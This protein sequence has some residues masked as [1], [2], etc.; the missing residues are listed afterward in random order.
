MRRSSEA[1]A[2]AAALASASAAAAASFLSSSSCSARALASAAAASAAAL[3]DAAACSA[4][5]GTV[6]REEQPKVVMVVEFKS[7]NFISMRMEVAPAWAATIWR[8]NPSDASHMTPPKAPHSRGGATSASLASMPLTAASRGRFTQAAQLLPYF[9]CSF[10]ACSTSPLPSGPQSPTSARKWP[11]GTTLVGTYTSHLTLLY[12]TG[13]M[14]LCSHD[15]PTVLV[16]PAIT[17]KV[18]LSPFSHVCTSS[19]APSPACASS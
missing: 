7:P 6:G 5:E 13:S 12:M 4:R 18:R 17:W 9:Q 19:H 14:R 15:M 1:F 2:S 8:A 3:A 16:T 11:G 10:M